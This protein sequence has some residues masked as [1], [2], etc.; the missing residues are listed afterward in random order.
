MPSCCR[1]ARLR[2]SI[3]VIIGVPL[4]IW[5]GLPEESVICNGEPLTEAVMVM[6]PS[7]ESSVMLWI[8][9]V[10]DKSI[11]S[12]KVMEIALG[13]ELVDVQDDKKA[14]MVKR[15]PKTSQKSCFP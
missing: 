2:L 5:A 3:L 14:G 1:F 6:I 15:R 8:L 7:F 13:E 4:E 9:L 11:A 12:L 10:L